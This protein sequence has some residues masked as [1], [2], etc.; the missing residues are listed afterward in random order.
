MGQRRGPYDRQKP[1]APPTE[2]IQKTLTRLLSLS[3]N[4]SCADCRSLLVD[5]SQVYASVSPAPDAVPAS[6]ARVSL[7]RYKNFRYN[8]RS[9]APPGEIASRSQDSADPYNHS[10]RAI[11]DVCDPPVD[12]ALVA[13][14]RLGGGGHG[15]FVCALC[16][17]AHKLLGPS[18]AAVHPVQDLASWTRAEAQVL[19]SA[20]GNARAWSVF[21]KFLP[22]S[23]E[24]KRPKAES[25]IAD[26]LTFIR[27]KYEALA[28]VL[29]PPGPLAFQAWRRIVNMHPEWAG[30]W[31]A[32]LHS[33]SCSSIFQ[34]HPTSS[35]QGQLRRSTMQTISTA[36]ASLSRRSEL[37]DRLVDYFCVVAAS[38]LVDLSLGVEDLSGLSSP[39]DVVLVPQVTDCFPL[40]E[41]HGRDQEFP[42]HVST[43]LFPDGCRPSSMSL[44]PSF[45]TF[46]LTA[47][48][49]DRLYGGV[50]RLYD[51]SRDVDSLKVAFE[52]SGYK[53][54]HPEW[55]RPGKH[56]SSRASHGSQEASDIVF[57]P[58]CLVV[59]SHYPFFDLWRKFLLQIYRIALVGAPLP[60]E[61][62]I[63]N[64]TCEI[65]LPPPGKIRVKFGFA[66]KDNWC[67]ERPPENQLPLADFSFRPLFTALSIP[68]VLIVFACLLQE[69]RVALVC[70]HYGILGPVA[71][72][73]TS[74]L[75]PLHWEGMY[76][77]VLPYHMLDILDAPVPYLVGLHS[78]YLQS[79]P[80]GNR[81]RGVVFVDLDRDE[82][83]LGYDDE[84]TNAPR[85]IPCLPER[86]ATKLKGKLEEFAACAY[87]VPPSGNVGSVTVGDGDQ[88]LVKR[89]SQVNLL[90]PESASSRSSLGGLRRRDVF[91]SADKAYRDNE[92][93][94]PITGFLSE[95]GQ[96]FE[97][98]PSTPTGT[99]SKS[100]FPRFRALGQHARS[101]SFDSSESSEHANMNLLDRQDVRLHMSIRALLFNFTSSRFLLSNSAPWLLV[102]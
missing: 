9:F 45:F 55:L 39:E 74:L 17:A 49:G 26:R 93:Q 18:V 96:F 78:R 52:N 62:F 89:A 5:V 12:P 38:D 87:V 100:K 50:L 20:G 58:K 29:P 24:N 1:P 77:P 84:E 14:S 21:E 22:P 51:E 3:G 53:G 11:P 68:N 63:A 79:T 30:L 10:R 72:A 75:F 33:V 41:T 94:V 48:N 57:L 13:H 16:G 83:H 60:I 6:S 59:I 36:G 102:G 85:Q 43:F 86:Q 80:P 28:F 42:E 15:V 35:T 92:L 46:V 34:S 31:G 67:V 82:V 70:K 54:S 37:P 2:S 66:V 91:G 23:W 88:P 65:P 71:E 73:L 8:H 47:S 90:A 64:F 99:V 56:G 97:Q 81:P 7:T 61:R 32:D 98:I 76:I 25:D 69:C 95:H 44:P 40:P 27:A 101:S 19:A 4:R